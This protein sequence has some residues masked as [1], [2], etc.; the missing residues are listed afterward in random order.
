M[1]P[2]HLWNTPFDFILAGTS[3]WGASAYG[4]GYAMFKAVLV[5]STM[6]VE[7]GRR[8]R[9]LS[10]LETWLRTLYGRIIAWSAQA[11]VREREHYLAQAQH[12]ADLEDRIRRYDQI[13]LSRGLALH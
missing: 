1:K 5:R 2:K 4:A 11:E 7:R 12:I 10:R 13:P 6:R 9:G 8:A 3:A